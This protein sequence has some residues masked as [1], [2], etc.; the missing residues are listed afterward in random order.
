[1]RPHL[2]FGNEEKDLKWAIIY[3]SDL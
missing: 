3:I 1:M 2:K